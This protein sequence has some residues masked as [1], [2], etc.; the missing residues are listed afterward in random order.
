M[1]A[2]DDYSEAK[3]SVP[4]ASNKLS[5]C[6]I[7]RVTDWVRDFSPWSSSDSTIEAAKETK[8]GTKVA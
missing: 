1:L 4:G 3:A 7:D 2:K 5:D 6:A 8:F